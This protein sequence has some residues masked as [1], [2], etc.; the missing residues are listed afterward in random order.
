MSLKLWMTIKA[1]VVALFGLGFLLIPVWTTSLF[2]ASTDEAGLIL[3]R[4]FG[5]AWI[6]EAILLWLCK[7]FPWPEAKKIVIAIVISNII[8]LV[9]SLVA[10]FSGVFVGIMGWLAAALFLLFVLVFAY[11]LFIKKAV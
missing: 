4:F 2:G 9:I 8:G 3:A 1:I 10:I 5:M 7:N 6:F 11:F